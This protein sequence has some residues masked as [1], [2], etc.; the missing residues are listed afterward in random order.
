[1]G[2]GLY[3]KKKRLRGDATAGTNKLVP[4]LYLGAHKLVTIQR[5][6][7]IIIKTTPFDFKERLRRVYS[8]LDKS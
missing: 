1:M 2:T 6:N 5:M 7:W 4:G 8:L 3:A